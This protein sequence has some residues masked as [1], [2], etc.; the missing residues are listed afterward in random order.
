VPPVTVPR[1]TPVDDEPGPVRLWGER[2][3]ARAIDAVVAVTLVTLAGVPVALLDGATGGDPDSRRGGFIL[4]FGALA[5]LAYEVVCTLRFGGTLGKQAMRLR[6]VPDHGDD[7]DLRPRSVAIRSIT[8]LALLVLCPVGLLDAVWPLWDDRGRSVHDR[9]AGT[10]VEP[11]E[12]RSSDRSCRSEE[13]NVGAGSASGRGA[14]G[15]A[16]HTGRTP[17]A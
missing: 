10:R 15:P 6:I 4:A 2:I 3:A 11:S 12:L 8:I 5:V 16:G 1:G 14:P 9:A 17:G 7:G 13:R